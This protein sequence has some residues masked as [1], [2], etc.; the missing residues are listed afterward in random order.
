MCGAGAHAQSTSIQTDA[1]DDAGPNVH[2][3]TQ[4]AQ[5]GGMSEAHY[6][7][8]T[9]L[10][11]D[12]II[13][14]PFLRATI[15]NAPVAGGFFNVTNTGMM[16][17]HL[18]SVTSVFASRIEIHEMAMDG[19]IMRMRELADGLLVPAGET[20]ML[21]SGSYHIMFMGLLKPLI[22][23]EAVNVTLTFETAGEVEV[24]FGIGAPN[25][26]SSDNHQVGHSTPA[27][28]Q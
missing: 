16:D 4:R 27:A 8:K 22:E 25:A 28:S 24:T 10:V 14:D 23:C 1:S 7:P 18:V 5:C 6:M 13:T 3:A 20:V 21:K 11:D 9:V 12:L 15:P 26:G 19:D 17:D 2:Y